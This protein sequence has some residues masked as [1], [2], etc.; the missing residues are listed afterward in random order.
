[1]LLELAIGDSYGAPFEFASVD[2]VT[3]NNDGMHYAFHKRQDWDSQQG[4]GI[5]TDDTQMSIALAEAM[6]SGEPWTPMLIAGKFLDAFKRDKRN[7]YARHFQAFLGSI[8]SAEEFLTKISPRSNRAGSAMRATPIGL[9]PAIGEVIT[10]SRIQAAITHNTVEGQDA[11]IA[12]SL[13]THYFAYRLGE[14]AKVGEF[15]NRYV[16]GPWASD[17]KGKVDNIGWQAVWA[18]ITALRHASSMTDLLKRSVAFLGDV[19]TVAAISCA[20]ASYSDEIPNDLPQLLIDTLENG[21]FGRDYLI[22]LD[23]K[24][25]GV[26]K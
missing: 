12:S 8:S 13:M 20:A 21:A 7:G 14:K 4:L 2:F 5:Y 17:W 11:A 16:P 22:D 26:R 24:L 25:E 3:A 15:V 1:M 18:A 6:I 10:K 19:D 23:S 9:Y